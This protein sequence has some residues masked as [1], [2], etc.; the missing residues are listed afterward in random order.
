MQKIFLILIVCIPFLGLR[1]Q[2]D[3]DDGVSY[4]EAE[5]SASPIQAQL[6]K[7]VVKLQLTE[8]QVPQVETLLQEFFQ[9][10]QDNPPSSPQEKGERRRQLRTSVGKL[11]TPEQRQQMRQGK[12]GKKQARRSNA[13]PQRN[14]DN[15]L[16]RLI[17]DVAA[18]LL[19]K[20]QRNRRGKDG[21]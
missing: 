20:R 4:E 17:D 14:S 3:Y 8:E 18:P 1:A 13:S 7:I 2:E 21:G 6:D 12:G 9:Q 10:R 11:L 19:E 15:W 16:D 5:T